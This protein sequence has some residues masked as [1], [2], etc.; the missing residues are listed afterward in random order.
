MVPHSIPIPMPGGFDIELPRFVRVRQTFDDAHI[1]DVEGSIA[2]EFKKFAAVDLVGKR[3]AVGI[4]SRGI[5]PQPRVA[6]AVIAELKAAGHMPGGLG[7][8]PLR[9]SNSQKANKNWR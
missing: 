4:G 7:K 6:R 8:G 1:E 2:R 3:V 5:R 9:V